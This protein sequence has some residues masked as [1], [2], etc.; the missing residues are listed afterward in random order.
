MI[1]QNEV[2]VTLRPVQPEDEALLLE[3]YGSTR[4]EELSRVPW[5]TE[6][7]DAFVRMQFLAQTQHYAAEYPRASHHIVCLSGASVGRLYLDRGP[8]RFHI[9]DVT[10]LPRFRGNGVGTAVL[11]QIAAEAALGGKPVTIYVESFNPS[12]RLF[13]KLGFERVSESGFQWLLR[14][15]PG[16]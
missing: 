9:L 12:V 10:I 3:L 14:R 11:E 8:E 2:K 15:L 7:K 6:Q 5:S 1:S 13:G 4:A 16:S